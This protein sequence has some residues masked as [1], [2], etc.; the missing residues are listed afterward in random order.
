MPSESPSDEPVSVVVT[1]QM[2]HRQLPVTVAVH[3]RERAREQLQ[4]AE[5]Q[6]LVQAAVH[7]VGLHAELD[8]L[9]GHAMRRGRGVLVHEA[10]G[11]GDERDVERLGDGSGELH[12]QLLRQL[13]DDLRRA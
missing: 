6:V 5:G 9:R 3:P 2:R 4:P 13:P 1:Q 7:V 8:Q 11:V 12:P 10:A